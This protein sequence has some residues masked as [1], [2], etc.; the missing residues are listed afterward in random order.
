MRR[1]DEL[2]PQRRPSTSAGTAVEGEPA[3]RETPALRGCEVCGAKPAYYVGYLYLVSAILLCYRSEARRRIHCRKHNAIHG[4]AYYSLTALTG[5][6]GLGVFAYPFVVF[7]AGR[8]LTP[9]LGKASY[10]LGLLPSV[11]LA[12][13]IVGWLL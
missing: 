1:I 8:N 12:A 9:A 6:I 2:R 7:A 11:G 3:L 13:L 5:W 4:L 10:V